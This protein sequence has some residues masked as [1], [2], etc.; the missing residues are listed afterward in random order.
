M[1]PSD[2]HTWPHWTGDGPATDP[3]LAVAALSGATSLRVVTIVQNSFPVVRKSGTGC[4]TI[5][6]CSWKELQSQ[7]CWFIK[8][9]FLFIKH[10]LL[11]H[12][13]P[14]DSSF[15]GSRRPRSWLL[16]VK[17][18]CRRCI[19]LDPLSAPTLDLLKKPAARPPSPAAG[20]PPSISSFRRC[21]GLRLCP[22]T[23]HYCYPGCNLIWKY[24][25]V[26]WMVL[27][28]VKSGCILFKYTHK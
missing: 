8:S 23:H 21:T 26:N 11:S 25:I 24:R 15:S 10:L 3:H 18:W 28:V 22:V 4:F 16:Q 27:D 5:A 17:I 7:T 9:M 6:N 13:H 14:D 20:V 12:V 2:F 19:K 1:L